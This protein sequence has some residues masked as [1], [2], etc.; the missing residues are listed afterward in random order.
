MKK[1]R[2]SQ[3]VLNKI[4]EAM[5]HYPVDQKK[6]VL[7]TGLLAIQEYYGYLRE[8]L[9]QELAILLEV[10]LIAVYEVASFYSLLKLNPEGRYTISVCTNVSCWLRGA[11]D[12]LHFLESEL[13]IKAGQTTSDGVFTIKEVECLAACGQ[14]P[15]IQVNGHYRGPETKESLKQFLSNPDHEANICC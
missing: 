7:K 1:T 13:N 3:D 10:P 5:R 8:D 2:L 14:A 6:A 9:M 4:N 15:A 11:T 12:L